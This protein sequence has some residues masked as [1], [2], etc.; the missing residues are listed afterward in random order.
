[1]SHAW[2]IAWRSAPI[3]PHAAN[4]SSRMETGPSLPVLS[5]ASLTVA[6]SRARSDSCESGTLSNTACTT[7]S[8]QFLV[9]EE[10]PEARR[11]AASPAGRTRAP[12]R[13]R[14]APR[15][16]ARGRRRTR[17]IARHSVSRARSTIRRTPR[18]MTTC[19]EPA[20]GLLGARPR[21]ADPA[22]DE[23]QRPGLWSP[24]PAHAARL[25]D[26][27]ARPSPRRRRRLPPRRRPTGS[28]L[29]PHRGRQHLLRGLDAGRC[30]TP[31][32]GRA[33]RRPERPRARRRPPTRSST[34]RPCS[35]RR[36][37]PVCAA[38]RRTGT[39][40]LT[41][42]S[43]PFT[44]AGRLTSASWATTLERLTKVVVR[45][46]RLRSY[47][48]RAATGSRA[49]SGSGRARP[50]PR[51]PG[52][53]PGR[54]RWSSRGRRRRSGSRAPRPRSRATGRA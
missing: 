19:V 15:R 29:R 33:R 52:W 6:S 37:D 30:V 14:S 48:R 18:M 54:S 38:C 36:R 7:R 24:G 12:R 42:T 46:I 26:W 31:R 22:C 40:G 20:G 53:R 11:P 49:P 17:R 23:H 35:R 1:M 16:G 28:R 3:T 2:L 4:S 8:A 50:R 25:R 34:A 41:I 9:V 44:S 5:S 21:R 27:R 43:G 13:T 10:Q 32:R 47:S 39:S 51:S 45:G